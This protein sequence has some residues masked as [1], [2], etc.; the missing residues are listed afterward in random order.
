MNPAKDDSLPALNLS[1][2]KL[3][4]LLENYGHFNA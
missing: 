1:M 4:V 2:Y 3:Q